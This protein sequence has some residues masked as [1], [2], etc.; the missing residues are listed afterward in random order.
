MV[1]KN[2]SEETEENNEQEKR[3]ALYETSRKVLLA[4]VGAAV[5]AQ[6]EIDGFVTRLTERGELAEK[7]ARKLMREVMDRREKILKE[8]Q[9][10]AQRSHP[11]VAT[12]ADIEALNARIAELT[13]ALEELKKS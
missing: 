11:S 2:I 7:D 5:L 3:S 6:E 9:A 12:K 4:A 8:K 1:K 13:K 10:E